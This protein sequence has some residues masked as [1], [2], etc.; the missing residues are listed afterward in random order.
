MNWFTISPHNE[1][2][3][4]LKQFTLKSKTGLKFSLLVNLTLKKQ[5]IYTI[6]VLSWLKI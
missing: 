2:L 1:T 6:L 4:V 5:V 3:I